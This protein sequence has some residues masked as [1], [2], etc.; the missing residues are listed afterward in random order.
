MM[1]GTKHVLVLGANGQTGAHVVDYALDAGA[2][3]T[4]VVR[5]H[6]KQPATHHPRLTVRVG[7]PC[8]PAF[9][10]EVAQGHDVIISTL[11]GRRPTQKALSVYPR[12]ARSIIRAVEGAGISTVIVTSSAL[13]FPPARLLDR[14]LRTLVFRV[15]QNA[16]RMEQSLSTCPCTVIVARCGFLN[17]LD[18]RPYRTSKDALPPNGSTI[19]R[20]TLARFLVE[21]GLAPS[22]VSGVF[23]VAN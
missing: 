15:V 3:V 11:G 20:K 23:G 4:A 7:D 8:D 13:L 10:A 9:L 2:R 18:E 22:P 12:S 19:S 14:V 21:R 16:A 17:D 1:D 5:S 6:A